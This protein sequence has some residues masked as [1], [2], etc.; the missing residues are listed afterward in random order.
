MVM[1]NTIHAYTGRNDVDPIGGFDSL[2]KRGFLHG[3]D[4]VAALDPVK[5]TN[6]PKLFAV[7]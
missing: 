3:P 5:A 4:N 2:P 1:S 7:K 6:F